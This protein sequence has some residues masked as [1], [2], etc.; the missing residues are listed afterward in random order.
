MRNT[1]GLHFQNQEYRRRK[2]SLVQ[3]FAKSAI[4]VCL[5]LDVQKYDS[6]ETKRTRIGISVASVIC[7]FISTWRKY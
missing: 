7:Q 5:E 1:D 2:V 6:Q 3:L 4:F